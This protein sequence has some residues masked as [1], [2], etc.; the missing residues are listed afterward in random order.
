MLGIGDLYSHPIKRNKNNY[1]FDAVTIRVLSVDDQMASKH[2]GLMSTKELGHI[3]V[4]KS[5]AASFI[6]DE[7]VAIHTSSKL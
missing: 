2:S 4:K 1:D 5:R 3:F 7:V 6:G